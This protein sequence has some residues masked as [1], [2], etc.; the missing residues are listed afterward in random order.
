M[1]VC[2]KVVCW[3]LV[4][5]KVACAREVCERVVW[6]S[7]LWKS[8]VIK[9]CV[10]VWQSCVCVKELCVCV[11]KLCACG[12]KLCVC[13]GVVCVWQSCA[14]VWKSC[15]RDKVGF[16]RVVCWRVVWDGAVCPKVVVLKSC[17][18]KSCVWQK[19]DG[20]GRRRT[21]G[22]RT[23]GHNKKQE[24]HTK[25]WEQYVNN[26][27]IRIVERNGFPKLTSCWIHFT[28]KAVVTP[29]QLLLMVPGHW[30][31][32]K[33]K[34]KA[35]SRIEDSYSTGFSNCV[36]SNVFRFRKVTVFYA[37]LFSIPKG[38]FWGRNDRFCIL[39]IPSVY[40]YIYVHIHI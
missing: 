1:C 19:E 24:A 32:V 15:V 3:R 40:I 23:G 11:T 8:F 9:S 10:C 13:E 2:E 4:C 21:D 20:G 7:C 12:T 14:C 6:Q 28:I 27:W 35:S 39:C 16:E 25:I 5:D 18:R 29:P 37:T 31:K 22:R 33:N 17:V 30:M 36:L 26:F 38:A 34:K